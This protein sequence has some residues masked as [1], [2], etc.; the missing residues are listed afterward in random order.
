MA[1]EE[2][3]W[4]DRAQGLDSGGR[5][6]LDEALG[7]LPIGEEPKTGSVSGTMDSPSK[8]CSWGDEKPRGWEL[9]LLGPCP[10]LLIGRALL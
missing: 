10:T 1:D 4:F 5:S 8:L 9:G 7:Q 3:G 6:R 2:V